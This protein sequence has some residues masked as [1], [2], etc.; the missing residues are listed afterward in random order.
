M[1]T[2]YQIIES[3]N[4][5]TNHVVLQEEANFL[6]RKINHNLNGAS[7]LSTNVSN[8]ELTITYPSL[9]QVVFDL[10]GI[11]L[12]LNSINLNS[13]NVTVSNLVF[14]CAPVTCISVGTTPVKIVTTFTLTAKAN[15]THQDFQTTKYL[16][17]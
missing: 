14:T 13:I 17:M 11:Y 16:R 15:G 9:P 7:G 5:G 12:R 6:L 2:T 4:A 1:V 3:T 8:D 10:S